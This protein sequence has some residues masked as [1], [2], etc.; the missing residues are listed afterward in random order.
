MTPAPMLRS[1]LVTQPGAGGG[2]GISYIDP[3]A[4]LDGTA[5]HRVAL[6]PGHLPRAR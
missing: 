6:E 2:G 1:Q 3:V 4:S 5:Y